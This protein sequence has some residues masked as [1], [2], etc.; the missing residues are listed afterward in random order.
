MDEEIERLLDEYRLPDVGE[1]GPDDGVGGLLD[2]LD[3]LEEIGDD[4]F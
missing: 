3:E 4:C 2:D 1:A